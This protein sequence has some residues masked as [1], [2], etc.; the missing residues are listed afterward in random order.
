MQGTISNYS[1][2]E[3]EDI[4]KAYDEM[5]LCIKSTF[6]KEDK[7]QMFRAF[8]I[9]VEAHKEQR[10]K[11]GEPYII[12]KGWF[13]ETLQGY[14]GG[15]IAILRMDGDWYESTIDILNHLFEKVNEGGLIIIDDYF[16]WDGCSKAVHDFLAENKL[17]NRVRQYNNKVAY[18]IK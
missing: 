8:E 6:S 14:S 1:P 16:S 13:S 17:P 7:A 4:R 2:Q 15:N 3:L 12:H 9:A 5:I 18:I 10:R 11:S